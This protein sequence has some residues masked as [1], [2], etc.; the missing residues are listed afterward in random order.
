MKR[1]PFCGA[2]I[3]AE[4]IKCPYCRRFL[5][6]DVGDRS[7]HQE[8]HRGGGDRRNRGASPHDGSAVGEATGPASSGS[9]R[10]VRRP[11]R[12][13]ARPGPGQLAVLCP[14]C[15]TRFVEVA[16]RTWFLYGLLLVARYGTVTHVGC[17]QCVNSLVEQNL[18]KCLLAGWWCFPWGLFTPVVLL[19]NLFTLAT[20]PPGVL[21]D[22]LKELQVD[23]EDVVVDERGL[24]P[25]LRRFLDVAA[26]VI[27]AVAWSGGGS[28]IAEL[29]AGAQIL[30]AISDGLIDL[31]EAERRIR[32]ARGR[33][34]DVSQLGADDRAVLFRIAAD[35]ASADGA[36][37][38]AE[39]AVLH[40]LGAKLGIPPGVVREILGTFY[41][42]VEGARSK[43]ADPEVLRACEILG[44]RPDAP[45]SE[46][47]RRYRSLMMLHHP[48]RAA[49]TGAD[50]QAAHRTAQEI[51]WAYRVLVTARAEPS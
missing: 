18:V 31:E 24:T 1:C 37:S 10:D 43:E 38:A 33:A 51:N 48:D 41:G 17:L 49:A 44:V 32:E 35:A 16:K 27:A 29:R 50:Q 11:T 7:G 46:V 30:Q 47:R 4:A 28:G 6:D 42:H 40:D 2:R 9:A 26:G 23:P 20:K 25:G 36:L 45:V 8:G 13:G 5:V 34:L 3:Q 39:L 22:V 15:G 14:H 12:G 21:F 19:Q